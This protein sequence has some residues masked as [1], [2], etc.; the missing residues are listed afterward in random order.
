MIY[1]LIFVWQAYSGHAET[2]TA[3]VEFGSLDACRVTA[4]E[5]R[6]QAKEDNARVPLLLCAPKGS[7]GKVTP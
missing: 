7:T 2:S 1:V 4:A 6:K 3:S 5:I